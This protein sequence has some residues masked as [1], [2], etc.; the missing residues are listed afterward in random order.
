VPEALPIE[1][2]L[3]AFAGAVRA[4]DYARGAE[5]FDPNVLGFGTVIDRAEGREMLAERQWR[6]VW[7]ETR[8]FRF[9]PA[10]RITVLQDLACVAATWSSTGFDKA[11]EPFPRAGRA[12]IVLRRGAKGWLAV[13][14]HFSLCPAA[15]GWR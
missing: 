12:T 14:T 6:L 15:E 1:R 10:A 4:A 8:G 7:G 13:H 5:L 3:D 9:D 11:G 2:W